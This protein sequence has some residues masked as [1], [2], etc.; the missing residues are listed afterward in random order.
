MLE[1][2]KPKLMCLDSVTA[3]QYIKLF[4]NENDETKPFRSLNIRMKACNRE[5]CVNEAKVK[6]YLSQQPELVIMY[7][8]ERL[9]SWNLQQTQIIKESVF[10]RQKFELDFVTPQ[11][12]EI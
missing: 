7:N 3:S 2:L 10:E 9:S 1:S 6:E 11:I 12:P 8:R 4:G 5:D